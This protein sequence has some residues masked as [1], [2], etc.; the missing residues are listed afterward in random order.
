[1]IQQTDRENRRTTRDDLLQ[2]LVERMFSIMK[3]VHHNISPEERLLSPPQARLL[4]II[5]SRKEKGIAARELA[6]KMNVT[7]GAIT[8]FTDALVEKGLVRRIEDPQ[9]RRIVR[10][11]VTRAA[12]SRLEQVRAHF[13]MAASRSFSHL[14]DDE[15]KQLISLLSKVGAPPP[16]KGM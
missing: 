14:S 5:A 13:L 15:L 1:M 16:S 2:G 10:L 12:E 4:F 8:Q 9:D 11:T 6:E 7:P 3:Q